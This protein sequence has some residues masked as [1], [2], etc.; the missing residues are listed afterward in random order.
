MGTSVQQDPW[1]TA[2]ETNA[3]HQWQSG[4]A[5]NA[6]AWNYKANQDS[7]NA[8]MAMLGRS[9]GANTESERVRAANQQAL[10]KLGGGQ[11]SG[12]LK[13]QFEQGGGP[14]ELQARLAELNNRTKLEGLQ[15]QGLEAQI[16][17]QNTARNT[18][19]PGYTPGTSASEQLAQAM[20]LQQGQGVG[21][22]SIAGR[23]AQIQNANQDAQSLEEGLDMDIGNVSNVENRSR[24]GWANPVRW[25]PGDH[26]FDQNANTEA[27]AKAS[28]GNLQTTLSKMEKLIA[29]ATG[30][31]AKAH[32]QV[33]AIL[34]KHLAGTG[35]GD[36]TVGNSHMHPLLQ[37][38]LSQYGAGQSNAGLGE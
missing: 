33:G 13:Q 1:D 36:L 23:N 38:V 30:D 17:G 15:S 27:A 31:P 9:L 34:K 5:G 14:A 2:Q 11:T 16:Q 24:R 25:L 32:T 6:A 4:M 18:P 3:G 7:L 26:T 10:M 20:A 22:A 8:Q 19:L 35:A 28:S 37:N 29:I 12:L 21:G